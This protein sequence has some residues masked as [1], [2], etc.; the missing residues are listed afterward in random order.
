MPKARKNDPATSHDAADSVTDVT[1]TQTYILKVLSK[2]P[3][4]D[5]QLIE[6]YR[7]YKTAPRASESGIR[8]RR[9]ELVER[10]MVRDSGVRVKTPSGR[11]AIVWEL[12]SRGER[13][14]MFGGR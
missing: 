8:S 6:A 12:T 1:A 4:H 3:R 11:Q 2:K 7:Q 5:Y 10:H 13:E 14:R 9:A